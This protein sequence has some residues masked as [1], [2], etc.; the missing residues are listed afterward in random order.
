MAHADSPYVKIIGIA[1]LKAL[2]ND[3]YRRCEEMAAY[4]GDMPVTIWHGDAPQGQKSR[5]IREHRDGILLTT[6]ES[7]EAFLMRRGEWSARYLT[8]LVIIV[9][10]FHAFLG[11]GRGKQLLSLMSR[12]E[13][14]CEFA[15]RPTPVRIAL[16]ATLSDLGT[17]A[18][19]LDPVRGAEVVD[20]TSL[21]ID[22]QHLSVR[23]FAPTD[24]GDLTSNAPEVDYKAMADEIIE[25]SG[26]TKTLTF[27]RSR[28]DVEQVATTINEE[29]GE[30]YGV[31]E[32]RAF[33]HHG[34]LSKETREALEKRLVSTSKPTMAVATVTLELGIDIGDISKVF[35]VESASTV[36]SLRQRMGR[37]GRRN[38][39]RD[40]EIL[41]PVDAGCEEMQNDLLTTIAEVEL[42]NQG[43]F[44]PPNDRRRDLSV[45]A[46]ESMS[47]I[48]QY[49]SIFQD[50]LYGLLCQD[51]GAFGNVSPELFG[52][53]MDDLVAR[54]VL[55]RDSQGLLLLDHIG[56]QMTQ[57]WHFYAAFQDE[58][59]YEV[60]AG[61][62]NVGSVTPPETSLDSLAK[63]GTFKLGG[64]YW[65]VLSIDM[66]AKVLHV[67]RAANKAAFLTPMS[68]G[69]RASNGRVRRA[70]I[71][72]LNGSDATL[73]PSY[74]T[75]GQDR[76]EQARAYAGA[77]MLNRLGL[78]LYD[79][80]DEGSEDE[81]ELSRRLSEGY[82]DR[83]VVKCAPPL[84]T[85]GVNGVTLMLKRAAENPR[86]ELSSIPLNRLN[87]LVNRAME[88]ID[89]MIGRE[90]ELVDE[91]MLKSLYSREKNNGL[92]SVATL[93]EAYG[94][95]LIDL[96]EA[97]KWLR[98]FQRFWDMTP[99]QRGLYSGVG[100]LLR[101]E[102]RH[103]GVLGRA[104]ISGA[105]TAQWVKAI[106]KAEETE[107]A[108]WNL[109]LKAATTEDR[110]AIVE[111]VR[112]EF[113]DA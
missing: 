101:M 51:G 69:G 108:K 78:S 77:H 18:R 75:D 65:Q 22:E 88:D 64:K 8:P 59:A 97:R 48:T 32:E 57:D 90:A 12:I 10:E 9:D 74:L 94:P 49:G 71:S 38:G 72:L 34:L 39:M 86:L 110:K 62:H 28:A 99:T 13:K 52:H 87:D 55:S 103:P 14:M 11:E 45:L 19:M 25:G 53:A 104:G 111:D 93:A 91:T 33:P 102:E 58:E 89:G 81:R 54:E 95:E 96:A 56:D 4:C 44:E 80:G 100:T 60:H 66:S 40:M 21:G 98:G 7:L 109:A 37:S 70:V 68:S 107:A 35:Q 1:P 23:C 30:K 112:V 82:A 105:G 6:P 27:C 2:L 31:H 17:V 92:Y 43:W 42:M 29:L 83:A 24:H 46:S 61:N 85:A 113:E 3:Q 79:A 5:L 15:G 41:I 50:E 63:G 67:K 36:S 76:L 26:D 106:A 16:S 20:G 47:V 73:V 84:D